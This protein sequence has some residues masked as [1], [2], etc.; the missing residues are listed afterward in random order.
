MIGS[1]AY[2]RWSYFLRDDRGAVLPIMALVV[3][4]A[5]T[6]AALAVDL[7]R[8]QA[9]RQQLQLTADAAAL[10]AAINLP[11]V[12]AAREAAHRYAMRNMPDYANVISTDGIEFGQWDPD[13]REIELTEQG[14]SAVRVT[15]SLSAAKGNTLST[16]FAGLLG[17]DSLEITASA[18]AGKRSAMCILS[19]E[20]E[21]AFGLHLNWDS[22][23]EAPNCTVQVNS[24]H[25]WAFSAW[26]GSE[27]LAGGLCITGGSYLSF[28]GHNV[29]PEPT[30]G[31]PP[32]PDP[33]AALEAPGIGGCDFNDTA[34]SEYNGTLHPGV[35]C[36][37]LAISGSS[38]VD[39]AAGVYVIK[40][41]PLSIADTAK[42]TGDEVT[43]FLTGDTALVNFSDN[44]ELALTAPADGD[45]AGILVYQDRNF[46]GN[47]IWDSGA[48]NTLHGTIYLPEGTLKSNSSNA[49]TP[50]NSCN[51][52]IAKQ[53]HLDYQSS[54]SID[55]S[56]DHCKQYLPAAVLGTVALLG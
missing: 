35:Y 43:F 21:E 3:I 20:Q 24:A 29:S 14:P 32:Q 28:F 44:S 5:V 4:V 27:L 30:N 17:S 37:G 25:K 9:M 34:L 18:V 8:A 16:L 51:V 48:P 26:A 52:L 1:I 22:K 46:G 42:M 7:A 54:V 40:D 53:I 39:L 45:L 12:D 50:V 6:G 36:G 23:I 19:L 49:I 2:P 10:A 13:T 33:L 15:P 47:H 11:D 31:C 41:G 55:L 56:Q 38:D